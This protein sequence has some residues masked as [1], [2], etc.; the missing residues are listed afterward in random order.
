MS[1]Q[2]GASLIATV[3]LSTSL[4]ACSGFFDTQKIS[5]TNAWP[6]GK[7]QTSSKTQKEKSPKEAHSLQPKADQAKA[8]PSD[9]EAAEEI[10]D[11]PP[12][13][14]FTRYRVTE[15]GMSLS[16]LS[17]IVYGTSH[18]WQE[19]AAWNHI[20]APYPIRLG[21]TLELEKPSEL[22]K[23]QFDRRLLNL[24]RTRLA[25][26]HTSGHPH[27]VARDVAKPA[28]EVKEHKA[29]R[30]I[31]FKAQVK[32]V[33]LL[34]DK[35][36]YRV[37]FNKKFKIYRVSKTDNEVK[38]CLKTALKHHEAVRILASRDTREIYSCKL[39]P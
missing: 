35:K 13:H 32:K 14:P 10:V 12:H 5:S 17:S 1:V 9:Q 29:S 31:R 38:H 27:W 19:I 8:E 36:T 18:R 26:R 30:P 7:T 22:S 34:K 25:R 37:Q 33:K 39:N 23:A 3:L 16:V 2:M 6:F 15:P 28:H 11:S 20:Q 4:T 21:Q 24:W